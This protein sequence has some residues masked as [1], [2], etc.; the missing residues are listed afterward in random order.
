MSTTAL[1]L[2]ENKP[3]AR[4]KDGIGRGNEHVGSNVQIPRIKLLQKMSDEV[5]KNK[6]S[7]YIEGADPGH[8]INTLTQNNYGDELYVLPILFKNEYVVWRDRQKGGGL[9]GSFPTAQDAAQAIGEQDNP[10]D[11]N[12]VDTHSHLLI[13]K[14]PETGVLE[15]TPALMDFS[16]TKLR[17]S[18]TWNSQI[19]MKGGDRFSGLWMMK[20]VTVERNG[21]TW[22]NLDVSF[23]GW[24]QD[25]DYAKAEAVYD[26]YAN[27]PL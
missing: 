16:N 7:T 25:E 10:G 12:A 1:A 14:D 21:N 18:K 22:L 5:D 13:I 23:V 17:V 3:P 15:E 19:G 8:F 11:Y 9:L 2:P 24:A 26:Q 6:P 27:S 4:L 20:S